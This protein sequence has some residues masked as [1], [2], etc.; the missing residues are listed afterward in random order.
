MKKGLKFLLF[1]GAVVFVAGVVGYQHFILA[2]Y[3]LTSNGKSIAEVFEGSISLVGS[4]NA[5]T[6]RS[7]SKVTTV[8]LL[9]N[10]NSV[11]IEKDAQVAE[12]R[13]GGADNRIVIPESL[14]VKTDLLKGKNNHIGTESVSPSIDGL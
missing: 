7:G 13:G 8:T 2:D 5:I 1:M 6:I 3:N 12:I 9:G 14:T 11:I 4:Q 10:D